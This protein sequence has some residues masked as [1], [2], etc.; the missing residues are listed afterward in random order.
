MN[1]TVFIFVIIPVIVLGMMTVMRLI[2]WK[3]AKP[4]YEGN[5][6]KP[7][8]FDG[9]ILKL[10]TLLTV[11]SALLM[12]CGII[13]GEIEMVIACLIMT[14]IMAGAVVIL[15]HAYKISYEENEDYFILETKRRKYQVAYKDIIDWRPGFNEIHVLD[16]AHTDEKYIKVNIAMLKP[17]MLLWNIG[18]M[19]L[20]GKFRIDDDLDPDRENEFMNFL[21]HNGYAHLAEE[22]ERV[23]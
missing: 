7:G 21:N 5:T 6:Q 20:D 12:V 16:D 2:R 22:L 23:K 9:C 11:F 3:A 1:S 4:K 8:T 15:R 17:E 14:L 13:I 10:I 19:T 18:I